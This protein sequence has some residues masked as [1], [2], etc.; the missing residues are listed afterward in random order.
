M[1]VTTGPGPELRRI[2]LLLLEDVTL[3]RADL[4][5]EAELVRHQ[6]GR[7]GIE[8][9]VQGRHHAQ[10]EQGLDHLTRLAAHRGRQLAH[11]HRLGQLD[12]LALHL[13]RR[14]GRRRQRT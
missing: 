5:V 9:L 12:Q 14:L 10:L 1:T 3:E 7:G 6:L 2:G 8:H 11:R 4:H 13:D